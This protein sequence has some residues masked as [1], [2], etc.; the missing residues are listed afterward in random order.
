MITLANHKEHKRRREPN[1]VGKNPFGHTAR[2]KDILL[3]YTAEISD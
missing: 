1:V 3:F 2:V